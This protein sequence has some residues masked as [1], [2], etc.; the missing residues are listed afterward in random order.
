MRRARSG[1][2]VLA[3][4]LASAAASRTAGQEKLPEGPGLAARYLRDAGLAADPAVLFH[5]DFEADRGGVRWNRGEIPGRFCRITRRPEDVHSGS[6]ALEWEVP[7]GTDTG[8]NVGHR[9]PRGREVLFLRWYMKFAEDF[10]Q[11]NLTHTG[12]GLAACGPGV[13]V[14]GDAGVRA[15]GRNKYSTMLDPW[16]DW[17]R[18]P[19]PG[20]LILYTYHPDQKGRWGDNFRPKNKFIPERGRWYCL[21]I[22]L[23]TNR[24]GARDGAVAVWA[25]GRLLEVFGGLRLREVESLLPDKMFLVC[26]MHDSRKTNRVWFDDV[27]LATSYIGPMAGRGTARPPTAAGPPVKV[28][29][30]PSRRAAAPETVASWDTRLRERIQEELGAGRPPRFLWTAVGDWA[31]IT[32]TTP[33]GEFRLQSPAGSAL[34]AWTAL[35][36]ADRRNLAVELARSGRPGDH[37]LAAFYLLAL[38]EEEPARPHL[39]KAGPAAEEVQKA[40]R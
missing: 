32:E 23:R 13:E 37:A 5:D 25:D 27:V 39:E 34:A 6:G 15:D 10:D 28:G 11:G 35:S 12:G 29:P 9:L 30:P 2:A 26:Y 40:F 19:A 22:M 7:A 4:V 33:R 36:P 16:R 21:E 14:P 38:E 18:N 1:A 3:A 17:G 20:E 31:R 8:G 24:M